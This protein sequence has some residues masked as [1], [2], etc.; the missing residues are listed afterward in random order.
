MNALTRIITLTGRAPIVI[1]QADWPE[2]AKASAHDAR[3]FECD[4]NR[5]WAI[6]VRRHQD[7]RAIVYGTYTTRFQGEHDLRAGAFLAAG[8][9]V[10]EAIQTVADHLHAPDRLAQEC[11]EELPAVEV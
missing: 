5:R 7:G 1:Q 2:I 4:A 10:A 8:D 11:I 9:D 3:E 6:R